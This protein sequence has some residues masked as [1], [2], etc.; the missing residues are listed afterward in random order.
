MKIKIQ[1]I[2]AIH[3]AYVIDPESDINDPE[4]FEVTD[5]F[6]ITQLIYQLGT[7]DLLILR[8]LGDKM[9]DGMLMDFGLMDVTCPSCRKHRQTVPIDLES[10]LFT[11]YQQEMNAKVE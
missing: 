6:D 8:N 1:N 3:R 2:T 7:K 10:I 4:Y 11:R 5:T 9:F